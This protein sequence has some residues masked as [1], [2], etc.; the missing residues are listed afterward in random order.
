MPLA[1]TLRLFA[2]ALLALWLLSP[3]EARADA[4]D[5]SEFPLTCSTRGPFFLEVEG[6]FFGG[7]SS[8]FTTDEYGDC[9]I[10]TDYGENQDVFVFTCVRSTTVRIRVQPTDCDVDLFLLNDSC[11]PNAP[12]SCV[13]YSANGGNAADTVDFS[14]DEGSVYYVSVERPDDDV[15]GDLC[16]LLDSILCG[17][18]GCDICPCTAEEDFGYSIQV[19]CEENCDN[20]WD[21]D[22][23]GLED[24]LDP[25]CP[26]CVEQC[27]DRVDNDYDNLIDC[28]DPDRSE[29]VV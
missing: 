12:G 3:G 6:S 13:D 4:C 9:G 28:E 19:T 20:R 25:D 24:C 21:D 5:F 8:W 16:S 23:D 1:R 15:L 22:G 27:G 17:L 14:C 11:N 18:F 29:E 7:I 10:S 26:L 2:A